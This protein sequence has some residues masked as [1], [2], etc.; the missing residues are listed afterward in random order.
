MDRMLFLAM[1]GVKQTLT[2]QAAAAHNLANTNTTGFRADL[3]AFRSMPVFGP[4]YPTR[5]YAMTE[6]PGV[7][8]THGPVQHTGNELDV[9]VNGDGWIAVQ[10]PD[11][12]EAYTRRGD[13]RL[14]SNGFLETGAGHPVLGNGGPIAIPPA[15]KLEIGSD[16]TIS[17]LPV[18]Q[19]AN[20]LAQVE[21]IKLV[22]PPFEFLV[23]GADGL[24]RLTDGTNALADAN[25]T[26]IAGALEGSNVNGV[27]AMVQM[28]T[29]ARQFELQVQAM[30]TAE[31]NDAAAAHMMRL[32]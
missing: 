6:R 1:S 32:S 24:F 3:A 25:V 8:F 23:K 22:N 15:E 5:V 14:T 20:T 12:A 30:H 31:E 19:D 16:G 27:H 2:A 10:S 13:L 7:D 11:G 29:L 4:G 28:I 21:R 17:V 18:G 26:V 9:A